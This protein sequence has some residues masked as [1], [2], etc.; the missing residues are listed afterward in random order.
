MR[1]VNN[2]WFQDTLDSFK[3]MIPKNCV[4]CNEDIKVGD[5]ARYNGINRTYVVKAI[6]GDMVH[7]KHRFSEGGLTGNLDQCE[8]IHK[9]MDYEKRP[10][11]SYYVGK[12][13]G[14]TAS[15]IIRDFEL[16]HF[17]ASALE[18]ILRSANKGAERE[19]LIKAINH[20]KMEI[21]YG[22]AEGKWE[23]KS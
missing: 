8:K 1:Y 23:T 18:Y 19:D 13:K 20:L 12:H 3:P 15:D 9:S 10:K 22:D 16:S 14:I 21:E 4:E 2:N 7:L 5:A 11:P 6:E 17:K